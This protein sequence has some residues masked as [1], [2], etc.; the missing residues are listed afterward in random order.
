MKNLTFLLNARIIKTVKVPKRE[1]IMVVW[2][3][4]ITS[5]QYIENQVDVYGVYSNL[6]LAGKAAIDAINYATMQCPNCFFTFTRFEEPWGY[7]FALI[8]HSYGET[9]QEGEIEIGKMIL[10]E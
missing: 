5:Y 7:R 1:G 4:K 9:W 3:V 6:A 10:N 2:V 8:A